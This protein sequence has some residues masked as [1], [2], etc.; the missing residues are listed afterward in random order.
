MQLKR[1]ASAA[2]LRARQLD[3]RWNASRR[4]RK[5][6]RDDEMQGQSRNRRTAKLTRFVRRR[7]PIAEFGEP[8]ASRLL[9]FAVSKPP[10]SPFA[11]SKPVEVILGTSDKH[12]LSTVEMSRVNREMED[13]HQGRLSSRFRPI[14]SRFAVANLQ[15]RH[16]G[17]IWR[18]SMVFRGCKDENTSV[19]QCCPS[20]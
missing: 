18:P 16:V 7:S 5:R 10:P 1:P 6:R 19:F 17:G 2:R 8:F 11:A 13:S 4:Q 3:S 14:V 20:N 12:P 15:D 9:V